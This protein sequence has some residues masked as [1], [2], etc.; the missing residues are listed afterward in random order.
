MFYFKRSS[1]F[2]TNRIT[3]K[4]DGCKLDPTDNIQY[5]GVYIDKFISWDCH[6]IQ[7]SNKLSQANGIISKLRHFTTKDTLLS[8][9]AIF[10]SHMS[11][12]VV[13]F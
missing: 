3:L 5:L 9:Y 4:L 11:S 12:L 6:I 7:L 10:Y 2:V 13:Y 8:V 1:T